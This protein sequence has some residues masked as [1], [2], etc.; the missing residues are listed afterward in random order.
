MP[1][2]E[3][4]SHS[5]STSIS[6]SSWSR[7]I[8]ERV[9][10][11]A[12]T[13]PSITVTSS[14]QTWSSSPSSSSSSTTTPS[15]TD[16][17]TGNDERG[18]HGRE[19]SADAAWGLGIVNSRKA[20]TGDYPPSGRHYGPEGG[21]SPAE[22]EPFAPPRS[23][24][25]SHDEKHRLGR[26]MHV[27]STLVLDSLGT[28]TGNGAAASTRPSRTTFSTVLYSA[29]HR[30]RTLFGS[31]SVENDSNSHYPR[32]PSLLR[33]HPI[34]RHGVASRVS[35]R[36]G[37]RQAGAVVLLLVVLVVAIQDRARIRNSAQAVRSYL[38]SLPPPKSSASRVH[39]D[40]SQSSTIKDAGSDLPFL[41]T[42]PQPDTGD[43]APED[44]QAGLDAV[45]EEAERMQQEGPSDS[46]PLDAIADEPVLGPPVDGPAP[47][48]RKISKSGKAKSDNHDMETSPDVTEAKAQ[49]VI[50]RA[51]AR[52]AKRKAKK[53]SKDISKYKRL[54]PL[55]APPRRYRYGANFVIA[56]ED[57]EDSSSVSK[58]ERTNGATKMPS[59]QQ[60]ARFYESGRNRYLD[61]EAD[62]RKFEWQAPPAHL[63]LARFVDNLD[64]EEIKLRHWTQLL[65]QRPAARG[66]GLGAR[67]FTA[68]SPFLDPLPVFDRGARQKWTDLAAQAETGHAGKC[69]GSTWLDEYQKMHAEMLEGK[70]DPHFISYHCEQGINCGGLGD[71]L[72]GMT[73]AFFF[74]LIT[75]RAFL[76]EWQ[77]P[78]PLDVV[79]DSPHVNWSHSSFTSERHPILGQKRLA[80]AAADLDIIHFDRLAVDAT[81]GTVSWN[82]KRDRPVT[83]GF[84]LR[85]LAY[86]S[87]WIKF[88][89]NRGMVHRSFKYKHLQKRIGQ[90]GLREST[91]FSCI[92]DY[93]FRPKP[94]AL[95]LITQY[96]SVMAL[97]TVF[98]VGIHIRTGDQ[99]MR[100]PQ[101][102]KVNTVKR[103]MSFFR[104]ARELGETYARPD[105]RVVFYLVTDSQHLKED[106]QRVLGS[107]LIMTDFAPQHVHQKSGHV[108]GVMSA[109]VEDYVLAEADML[110]A[111]QDSGFGKLASFMMAKPNATVTI[112]P[113][114]NPDV[115]GLRNRN[116]H[117]NVDCTSPTVFT[118]FEELSSEWSLG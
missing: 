67:E 46:D 83:P 47:I 98:S 27:E 115:L 81:F 41:V 62:W 66:V 8:N 77:A 90:L 113:R 68:T 86:R 118:S 82:A 18:A 95:D 36:R 17:G 53:K 28:S 110:V 89:S 76:A 31:S 32:S 88:F 9:S 103:H 111:T 71:R 10:F 58:G 92:S 57:T 23:L 69:E 109:V 84:E 75:Q 40:K 3:G 4:R 106:A 30:A 85:D 1:V 25:A 105:Q 101:Y 45:L 16:R 35:P 24:K 6:T 114:F 80:D 91:A 100:D 49:D 74:G 26:S 78:V 7:G 19:G 11:V 72:L 55:G 94:A 61:E 102:D 108:D 15:P 112:F 34:L 33:P 56:A 2:T 63:S 116:S 65:Q 64:A 99:S 5:R 39:L 104:C 48:F 54:L 51:E 93:L 44:E 79:F 43:I 117:V 107:K 22:V 73:S 52:A 21:L 70:R 29:W 38:T 14:T 59:K 12:P 50:D 60:L 97:P 87:P 42:S 20:E 37:M 13:S 96:T